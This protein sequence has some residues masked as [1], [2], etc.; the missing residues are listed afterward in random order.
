MYVSHIHFKKILK[1]SC[2]TKFCY[3]LLYK[4]VSPSY[5]YI[6]PLLFGFPSHLGYHR[7]LVEFPELDSGSHQFSISYIAVY[8]C[9]FQPP[10]SSH[11]SLHPQVSRHL[12]ATSV[13]LFLPCKSVPFL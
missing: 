1:Y 9:Q 10:N 7:A 13:S 3:F 12:F 4:K 5:V 6:Y 2:F 8:R 11:H